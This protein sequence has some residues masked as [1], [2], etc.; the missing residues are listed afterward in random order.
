MPHSQV[1]NGWPGLLRPSRG[2][3]SAC[4]NQP[5]AKGSGCVSGIGVSY[6]QSVVFQPEQAYP[7]YLLLFDRNAAC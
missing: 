3:N 5:V 4:C 1:G 2:F 7:A 6:R